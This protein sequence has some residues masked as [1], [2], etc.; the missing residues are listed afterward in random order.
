VTPLAVPPI[1]LRSTYPAG[2]PPLGKPPAP[3]GKTPTS[4]AQMMFPA[5]GIPGTHFQGALVSGATP[6]VQGAAGSALLTLTLQLDSSM[7]NFD[8]PIQFPGGS[9]L[10]SFTAVTYA[11]GLAATAALGTQQA[12]TDIGSFVLP[13]LGAVAAPVPP[14]V[15]LPVW[16]AVAP[17]SP[18][19]AWLHVASNTTITGPVTAV[20]VATGGT[21]YTV[22][23]TVTLAG[24]GSGSGATF[25]VNLTGGVISSVTVNNGGSGYPSSGV[26]AT[27][28]GG[29]ATTA[30]TAGAVT[31]TPGTGGG[32]ILV[33]TYMRVAGLWSGPA[34]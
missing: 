31:V 11:P 9:F 24:V 5:I 3:L 7:G 2:M 17:V 30:G 15:Q 6:G 10:T 26:T 19:Q 27:F 1:Q 25:T 32:A 13:A 20:A 33:I 14:S 16:S 34:K 23:P 8:L 18:F 28:T 21:G 12:G 4:I 22:A 29:T